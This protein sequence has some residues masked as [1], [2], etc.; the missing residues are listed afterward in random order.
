MKAPPPPHVWTPGDLSAAHRE[1]IE[2][3]NVYVNHGFAHFCFATAV[4][5]AAPFP[6]PSSD[7]RKVT[8]H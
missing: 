1:T 6:L 5:R 8:L 2:N 7:G 3:K 4:M